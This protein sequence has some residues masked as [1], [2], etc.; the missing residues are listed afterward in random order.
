MM[1]RHRR[2]RFWVG[3]ITLVVGVILSILGT[4]A[5]GPLVGVFAAP[6]ALPAVMLGL[7][8]IGVGVLFMS[9]GIL[10]N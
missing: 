2:Q 7:P 3:F 6:M 1:R 4:V 10:P 9:R 5:P 8:L